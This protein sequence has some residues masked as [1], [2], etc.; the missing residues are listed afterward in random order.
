VEVFYVKH[1][2]ARAAS[3]LNAHLSQV[4]SQRDAGDTGS[5]ERAITKILVLLQMLEFILGKQERFFKLK[6]KRLFFA[7]YIEYPQMELRHKQISQRNNSGLCLITRH[8]R[9][10]DTDRTHIAVF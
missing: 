7:F 2:P 4:A 10:R 9:T 5:N 8:C 1:F 3:E 6:Y